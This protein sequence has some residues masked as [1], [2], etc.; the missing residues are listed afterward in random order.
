M[1]INTGIF[2]WYNI[3]Q[4]KYGLIRSNVCIVSILYNVQIC[5][6]VH[7]CSYIAVFI[8]YNAR[9]C[10]PVSHSQSPDQD[11]HSR[12]WLK[13]YLHGTIEHSKQHQNGKLLK[14]S[15]CRP[16]HTLCDTRHDDESVLSPTLSEEI[17]WTILR[18]SKMLKVG[19]WDHEDGITTRV[20]LNCLWSQLPRLGYIIL[21]LL[22]LIIIK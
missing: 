15:L 11:L 2:H 1:T 22:L 6:L 20:H 10:P 7:V 16:C 18:G 9:M 13:I 12:K 21:L 19:R 4:Y 8:W 3:A 17:L 5:L 14:V